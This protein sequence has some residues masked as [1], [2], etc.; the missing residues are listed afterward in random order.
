MDRETFYYVLDIIKDDPVF[1]SRGRRPQRA[2]KYQLAAYLCFVGAE[3]AIKTA[4]VLAIAEGTVHLYVDRVCKAL[5]RARDQHLAWPQG[6]RREY[7]SREGEKFG[8]P[9]FLGSGDGTYI[10]LAQKPVKNGWTYWCRKKYYSVSNI[11]S[12]SFQRG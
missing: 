5:R 4:S 7:L 6:P 8:F 2:P 1:V 10:P 9:G 11:S 12:F 3:S